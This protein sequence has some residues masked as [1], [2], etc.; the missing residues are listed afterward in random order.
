MT[1]RVAIAEDNS[2]VLKSLIERLQVHSDIH[3]KHTAPNGQV[4]I[5]KLE[6][7]PLVDLVLM[8]LQMPQLNGIETTRH[9]A[10]RWPQIRILVVTMFDDDENIFHAIMAGA[11]GYLLKEDSEAILYRGIVDTLK[12]GAAMSPGIALKVLRLIRK[13]FNPGQVTQDFGLTSREIEI[14]NQLKSGLTNERIAANLNISYFT[15]RKHIENIY[16][17]MKVNN[18]TEAVHKASDNNLLE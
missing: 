11:S 6:E 3:I 14:L 17:K 2:L 5:D 16:R 4:L 12:G 15:V 10:R 18:R 7:D 9:L 8:D 13:P 1:I